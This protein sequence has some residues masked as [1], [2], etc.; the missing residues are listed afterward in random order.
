M[1]QLSDEEFDH[2]ITRAMDE[3]PQEY[4]RGLDNVAIVYADEPTEEQKVKMK[5]DHNHLLLGLYEGIPLT[6][7]GSGYSF[8]LP[9]K[10]TLFKHSI[11]AIV[12]DELQLFEQIKRTLWHEIAHYYGVSHAR[13]D[14]LQRRNQA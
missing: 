6:Q 10:I 4:I 11:S 2:L 5:L 1:I 7:R 13:M 12:Q 9:D 8:V 14:E 3:L